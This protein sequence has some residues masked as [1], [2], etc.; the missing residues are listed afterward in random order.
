[1]RQCQSR[2]Q[3]HDHDQ[4]VLGGTGKR[5]CQQ[6]RGAIIVLTA[7]LLVMMMGMLAFSIDVG[8][9]YTLD[10]Q[11]QR[12]VDA[13]ALAGAG[14]LV[15]GQE[16]AQD[17]VA[18]YLI[19]NPIG[20]K[21]VVSGGGDLTAE[22]SQFR[23]D[24]RDD[25]DVKLGHWDPTSRTFAES[26]Q[27]PS[28][29]SVAMTYRKNPLFFARF[30]GE[31]QF[32]ITAS[33]VAMYQPRDIMV[34]LDFSA[35]MNDDTE[36]SSIPIL[37]REVVEAN[38]AQ[39]WADLGSPTYGTMTFAPQYITV[40]SGASPA[41]SVEYRNTSV[42]VSSSHTLQ[43][44]VLT[45]SDGST[46]TWTSPS[47]SSGTFANGSKVVTRVVAKSNNVN[48]TFD[49]STSTIDATVKTALGLD[50]VAYPYS[51]GSWQS[52]IDWC[53][54]SSGQN[55]SPGGYR[56][57]FGYM[58]LMVYWLENYPEYSK[59]P[60]LW[61]VRAQPVTALKTSTS[62]FMEF[63]QE[64]DTNDR[65][66]LAIYNGPN[67]E[68]YLETG[69]THD[70]QDIIHRVTHR[71]A[72]HYHQYT[73][74]GGGLH[75]GR[76]ELEDNGRPGAFRMVVLMTDGLANWVSGGQNPSGAKNYLLA[77]AKK[78]ADN[79]FPVVTISLGAGADK[80]VMQ[81]VAD[82]TPKGRHFN[83]PGGQ[84]GQEYYEDL[85]E[86]FREIAQDRP[87]KLVK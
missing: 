31:K 18:E 13:A 20:G 61:K 37:G 74:I 1:M 77:E 65:V 6:R 39:C 68:G 78:C 57:K 42:F 19:R 35:S 85:L 23:S 67:G 66:G 21:P 86:V 7:I 75:S 16:D 81:Q 84:T 72:G 36:F 55:N 44:V 82:M 29:I 38:L 10:S 26:E 5:E 71:Q 25:L 17:R 40:S 48:R 47:G 32:D 76:V 8:Y 70:F 64:V 60:D 9:M 2:S 52:Y 41:T 24:H 80:N 12:S 33:S 43:S 73:N 54:S 49:F 3:C 28:T 87:L 30:L 58:S 59:I 34:V 79:G 45:F 51:H 4:R 11:L 22:I 46:K 56:W 83:V 63:I 14:A 62:A 50:G 69:L 27:M 53:Q 15:K